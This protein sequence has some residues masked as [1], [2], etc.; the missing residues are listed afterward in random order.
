AHLPQPRRRTRPRRHQHHHRGAGPRGRRPAG[1]AHP[2]R[3]AGRRRARPGG[4]DG[5][6][7]RV[8]HRV[9]QLR[10]AAVNVSVVVPDWIDDPA[11][12]SGG[13]R[14]DRRIADELRAT[15]WAVAEIAAA[16]SWPRPETE[17]L[18]ALAEA[19]D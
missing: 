13:S 3:R 14:Y 1:A 8:P 4:T 15:G 6:T 16:G 17:A 11:R 5:H 2:G 10:P 19:L 9:G 18:R 7:A 12:I